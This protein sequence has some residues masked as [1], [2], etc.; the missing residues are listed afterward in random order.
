VPTLNPTAPTRAPAREP[1]SKP[2]QAPTVFPTYA[3]FSGGLYD[4]LVDP[5]EAV[6]L[7]DDPGE[8]SIQASAQSDH[9]TA[10]F[11]NN[12]GFF[13]AIPYHRW[14]SRR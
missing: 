9:I 1:S 14:S 4:L 5:Y 3:P 13:C 10:L 11:G 8:S 12:S 6:D 2:S 7:L